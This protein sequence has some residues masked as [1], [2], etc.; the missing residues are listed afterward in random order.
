LAGGLRA[1][2]DRGVQSVRL[3][4]LAGNAPARALYTSIGFRLLKA[5]HRYRKP[6]IAQ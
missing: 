3:H 4:T 5:F 1:L 2:Q 6:L